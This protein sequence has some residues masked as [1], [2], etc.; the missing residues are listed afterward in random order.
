MYPLAPI[1]HTTSKQE[2]I[3]MNTLLL[4]PSSVAD[5]TRLLKLIDDGWT[6]VSSL[7]NINLGLPEYILIAP[8]KTKA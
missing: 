3:P 5:E 6:V 2:I 4:R 7:Y 1:N 8:P